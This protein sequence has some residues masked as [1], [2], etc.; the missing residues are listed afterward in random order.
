M[1]T[2]HY[3]VFGKPVWDDEEQKI[4]KNSELTPE[5]LVKKIHS[6]E[7]KYFDPKREEDLRM[8]AIQAASTLKNE[9][10]QDMVNKANRILEYIKQ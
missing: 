7:T 4:V 8:Q 2:P 5:E 1:N 3:D 9:T 10:V 6:T